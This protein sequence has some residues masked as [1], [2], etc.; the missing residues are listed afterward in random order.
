MKI[1]LII[2]LLIATLSTAYAQDFGFGFGDA[3]PD[4]AMAAS[5]SPVSFKAGGEIAV[6]FAP[7][8]HEF[9]EKADIGEISLSALKLNLALTSS[10]V[11]V[12]ANFNFNAASVGELWSGNSDLEKTNHTPLI[13]DEAYL[14]GFLGPVNIEAGYRKLSWG[15]ADSMGPLDITNPVD[16]SDMRNITDLKAIKIARPMVHITWNTNNFSKLETVFIPNFTG[17]RFAAVGRWTP[18]QMSTV[19]ENTETEILNLT[20]GRFPPAYAGIIRDMYSQASKKFSAYSPEF[21]DTSGIEYSQAGLR[22]TTT[23]GSVDIGGQYF[24]GNLFRPNVSFAKKNIDAFIDDLVSSFGA[25]INTDLL[26]PNIK[27]NRYHQIG[28]D[29]AQVLFDFNVRA[30]AAV[31]LTEDLKGDDGSVQNPFIAWSLGFDRDLFWGIN[32][33]LQCTE[34]IRLLN[35]KVGDNPVYDAEADTDATSTR[36]TALLSKKFLRDNLECKTTVIWDIENSGCYIIPA[37]LWTSGDLTSEL[38]A[39]VFTGKE[40]GELGQ[41]WE[42][43]YIKFGIKYTF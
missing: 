26:S 17:H 1:K 42:N 15:K 31:H 40:T 4:E 20:L 25:S 7:Y 6:F 19:M 39:G 29:Y 13:I 18:S 23:I 2:F 24:Y 11:E 9:N 30:E 28:I 37:V 10:Y 34:T 33:N 12:F 38:S 43:T 35:D 27:Y 36:I 32:L 16:Y 8:V 41:Y 22:Y 5:S 3:D 21:P 14:R